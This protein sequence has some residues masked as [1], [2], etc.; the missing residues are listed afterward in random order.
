MNYSNQKSNVVVINI[1]NGVGKS[2][3]DMGII[4]YFVLDNFTFFLLLTKWHKDAQ[5]RTYFI[6]HVPHP[7]RPQ[8]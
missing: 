6:I 2:T 4:R 8:N 1:E 5:G 3:D 7:M